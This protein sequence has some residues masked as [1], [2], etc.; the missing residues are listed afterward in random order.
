MSDGFLGDADIDD[1]AGEAGEA[2][3]GRHGI[4]IA[5][6]VEDDLE[7]G[8]VGQGRDDVHPGVVL[9]DE[10]SACGVEF[11]DGDGGVRSAGEFENGEADGTGADDEDIVGVGDLG[12]ID[13]VAADGECFNEGELLE[14][15]G[16]AGMEL[17]R[18][19]DHALAHAAVAMHAED[20]QRF[21][22]VGA[23]ALAGVAGAAVEVR[24]DGAAVAD[25][26]MRDAFTDGEDFDAEFMAEDAWELDEGHFAEVA[27]EV[28]AADADGA[29]GDEGLA[30]ARRMRFGERGPGE[31]FGGGEGEGASWNDETRMTN[32]EWLSKSAQLGSVPCA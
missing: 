23:A 6:G 14:V 28:G 21:A 31:G 25:A 12:A 3:R 27:A 15:E 4:R 10:L 24:L 2:Q 32:D 9:R 29:D 18:G 20:L 17:V 26:E 11:E 5:G 22:A 7:G 30:V 1:P 8:C 19:K 13:G 16:V